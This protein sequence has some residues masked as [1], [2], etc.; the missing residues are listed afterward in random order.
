MYTIIE[1]RDRIAALSAVIPSSVAQRQS[2][3]LGIERSLPLI[4]FYYRFHRIIEH[5]RSL[6]LI[7]FYV[8]GHY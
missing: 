6:P 7:V 2:V 8:V 5:Y 4:V 1:K 3:G